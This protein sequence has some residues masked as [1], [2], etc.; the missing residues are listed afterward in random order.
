MKV[1]PRNLWPEDIAVTDYVPPVAIL[2]E[3]GA[4]LGHLTKNLVKGDVR[5]PSSEH[6]TNLFHYTFELVAPTLYGYRYELFGIS[7][8]ADFYPLK[9]DW[10][11]PDNPIQWA[12]AVDAG[13]ENEEQCLKALEGIFS[14]TRT[15][16]VIGSLI[17]Q[18]RAVA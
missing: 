10:D 8:G 18:S 14:S 9:I 3:Q 6:P 13:I 1:S 7:H 17:A 11:S 2:K 12:L 5:G 15:R 4:L 16:R